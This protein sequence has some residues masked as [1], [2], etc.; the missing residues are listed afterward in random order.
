MTAAEIQLDTSASAISTLESEMT[1]A[2]IQLDTS[3]SAISTLESEM[4]AAEI[5]L[6]TSAS[7]IT[8]L[9]GQVITTGSIAVTATHTNSSVVTIS[10]GLGSIK[11]WQL[12]TYGAAGSP[13]GDPYVYNASGSL[14]VTAI[15]AVYAVSG[16]FVLTEGDLYSWIAW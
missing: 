8:V 4:T 7:A 16:S 3:A 10:T 11:G 12:S 5:Q 14:M 15:D 13:L 6:D 1:A 9:Q 2:E